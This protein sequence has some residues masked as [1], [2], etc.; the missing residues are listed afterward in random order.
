MQAASRSGIDSDICESNMSEP[1]RPMAAERLVAQ[2]RRRGRDEEQGP[3]FGALLDVLGARFSTLIVAAGHAHLANED[4]ALENDA[5]LRPIMRVAWVD[6]AGG[7]AHQASKLLALLVDVQEPHAD[8]WVRRRLEGL[9]VSE[10]EDEARQ[11]LGRSAVDGA[12]L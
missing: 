6:G 7:E 8:T 11:A 12:R 2:E 4:F 9:V 3:G 5:L 1:A 10:A